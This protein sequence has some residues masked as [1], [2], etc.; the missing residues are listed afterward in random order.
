MDPVT[1]IVGALAVGALEGAGETAATAVKDAYAALR[2]AISSR[3]AGHH[4][5]EVVLAEHEKNPQVYEQPLAAQVRDTGA[6]T[7]PRIVELA[8]ALMRLMDDAGSRA[9]KYSVDLRDARGVQVGDRN[10]QHNTFG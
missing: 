2:T 3:F 10:T 8:Q 5:A 1:L 4:T 7:D 6:A 9:G